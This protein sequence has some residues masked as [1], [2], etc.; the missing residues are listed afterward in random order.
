MH[1]CL[2]AHILML[3][4]VSFIS[5][6]S[7]VSS[8]VKILDEAL[9]LFSESGYELT[10]MRKLADAVGIKAASLYNHFNSKREI[11]AELVSQNGP[12]CV[13]TTLERIRK[14]HDDPRVL[15]ERFV[16]ALLD[17][18]TRK[19]TSML[20]SIFAKL[21]DKHSAKEA[22][23]DGLEDFEFKLT[24]YFESWRSN[25]LLDS[26]HSAEFYF[27]AYMSP[28]LYVRNKIATGD[29][30]T[31]QLEALMSMC[32]EHVQCFVECNFE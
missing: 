13:A 14:E 2:N 25:G 23:G 6:E 19:D 5:N 10:S 22:I 18:W 17:Q 11:L 20:L 27:F 9:I 32:K 12:A 15:L 28:L 21:P 7:L 1:F 16:D 31:M 29:V 30:T 8:R 26:Q 24:Q 4:I 3:T